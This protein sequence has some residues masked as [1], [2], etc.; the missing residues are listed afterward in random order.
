MAAIQ[1]ANPL[2]VLLINGGS[3]PIPPARVYTSCETSAAKLST[4]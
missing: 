2:A 3:D 1:L 4:S